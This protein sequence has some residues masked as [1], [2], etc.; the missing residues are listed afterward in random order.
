M[1]FK[2]PTQGSMTMDQVFR[3]ILGFIQEAPQADYRLIVGTDSQRK[4]KEVTVVTA[5]VIHRVGKGARYFHQDEHVRPM[6]SLRQRMLYEASRSLGVASQLTEM[7]ARTR[8][9]ISDIEVHLDVGENGDTKDVIRDVVGMVTGSGY[10]ARIKPDSF[11]A[12]TVADK[13]TK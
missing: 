11:G 12:S 1:L 8:V 13:Y 4:P 7:L 5:I 6:H 2:S 3:E 10:T 9:P